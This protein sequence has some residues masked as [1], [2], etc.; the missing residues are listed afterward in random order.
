MDCTSSSKFSSTLFDFVVRQSGIYYSQKICFNFCVQKKIIETCG[1]AII[2][3]PL[4]DTSTQTCSSL[5]QLYCGINVMYNFANFSKECQ[6]A[7]PRE[8]DTVEYD[9]STSSLL[10]P[11]IYY[12]DTLLVNNSKIKGA[13]IPYSDI[14]KAVLRLNVFYESV[15][16]VYIEQQIQQTK[17]DFV[18]NLGGTLGL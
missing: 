4:M 15:D 18:S 6:D 2:I 12:K 13:G 9:T 17:E 1:C 3:L 16:Y 8:C 10:Y 11:S 5:E 7:C 14:D